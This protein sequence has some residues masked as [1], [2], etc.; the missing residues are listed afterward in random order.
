MT[1]NMIYK[2]TRKICQINKIR[3]YGKHTQ[4]NDELCGLVIIFFDANNKK[5]TDK[6]YNDINKFANYLICTKFWNVSCS[7]CLI[8]SHDVYMLIVNKNNIKLQIKLS[9]YNVGDCIKINKT[10]KQLL[11]VNNSKQFKVNDQN[12]Y[13]RMGIR[14]YKSYKK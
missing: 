5:M 13:T 2:N 4:I 12:K 1:S 6:S 11:N 3:T 7:K 8:N 14:K 9:I 10:N